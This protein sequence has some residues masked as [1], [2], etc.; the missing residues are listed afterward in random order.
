MKVLAMDTSNQAMSIAVLENKRVIGEWTTNIK[1]N[2]SER[3]M[4]AIDALLKEVNESPEQLDRIVVAKGPGSY[5]GLRI[6]VTTAK[7]LA[8]TLGKELAG[9]S[10]IETLAANCVGTRAFIVPL[11]DARRGNIYTGLYQYDEQGQ[12]QQIEEDTHIS[13]EQWAE[14]LSRKEGQFVLVGEDVEQYLET[15]RQYLQE[16]VT[17]APS[18]QHLPR[19]SVLGLLGQQKAAEDVHTFIPDYLK[20]AEAEENWRKA[21]PN[22]LEDAY[23]EKI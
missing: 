7:T 20:L 6:G 10:S 18:Q 8:W 16:R 21:H 4:P 9:V 13:A 5:T 12:L 15:F 14:Y 19:A 17:A 11:F 3:L 2:H 22:E 1:R 23:V